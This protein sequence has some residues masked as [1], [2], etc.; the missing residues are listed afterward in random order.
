MSK[1]FG[2]VRQKSWNAL[3]FLKLFLPHNFPFQNFPFWRRSKIV[4]SLWGSWYIK[5]MPKKLQFFEISWFFRYAQAVISIRLTH[6]ISIWTEWV[7][8]LGVVITLFMMVIRRVFGLSCI[9][10]ETSTFQLV[11]P[12]MG[13]IIE[14]EIRCCFPVFI[15]F[16]VG[17][18]LMKSL[19]RKTKK[20]LSRCVVFLSGLLMY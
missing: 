20:C 17:N 13:F 11:L 16:P 18:K 9:D 2:F 19:F 14:A 3:A 8:L 7:S 6:K 4:L 15:V 5:Q 10:G 12:Y 1:Y